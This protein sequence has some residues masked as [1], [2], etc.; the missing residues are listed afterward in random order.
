MMTVGHGVL[1]HLILDRDQAPPNARSVEVRT[2]D[3]VL[4][5]RVAAGVKVDVE[6]AEPLVVRGATR[7][8]T[9]HRIKLI[10][11]EWNASAEALLGE[12]RR[13]TAGFLESLGYEFFRP[14][15]AGEVI[16]LRTP[17]ATWDVFARPR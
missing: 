4:G 10:Q 11:F 3:Q 5:D 2:L 17:G 6:G 1:N 15:D 7:A 16:P 13:Q 9:E 8:L 14:G 12:E